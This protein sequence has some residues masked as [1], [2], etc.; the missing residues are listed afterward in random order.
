M[1]NIA[2]LIDIT[3]SMANE[4]EGVKQTVANLVRSVFEGNLPDVSITIIT[5]TETGLACVVTS[6]SFTDGDEAV[7]FVTSINLCSPPGTGLT[8]IYGGSNGNENQKAA[9]AELLTLDG[10]VPTIAFHITDDG[11]HLVAKQR[12]VPEAAVEAEYLKTKHGITDSDL[13]HVLSRVEAHFQGNLILSVIKYVKWTRTDDPHRLYGAIA[14]QF[15]GVLITPKVSHPAL[16]AAGLVEILTRLFSSFSGSDYALEQEEDVGADALASFTFYNLETIDTL[17][18]CEG[19]ADR[20]ETLRAGSTEDVMYQLIERATVIVGNKFAKRAIKATGMQEQ[21]E[22]LLVAAK[23]LTKSMPLNAALDRATELLEKIR[24]LVPE[25]NRGHIKIQASDLPRLLSQDVLAR[26]DDELNEVVSAIT[27]LSTE[28]TAKLSLG[29]GERGGADAQVE[30]GNGTSEGANDDTEERPRVDPKTLLQTVGS[31]F[32][33][34]LAVLQL[35]T[36]NG[37]VDF[38]DSWSSVITKVSNDV[39]TASDFLTMIGSRTATGGLSIRSTEYNY[40]QLFADPRDRVGSALFELASGTQVLDILTG[41][42]AGA[43][44]TKFA[45]NMFRG[46]VAACLKTLVIQFEPAPLSSFQREIVRKLAH[47]IRLLMGLRPKEM[48]VEPESNVSKLLFQLLRLRSNDGSADNVDSSSAE[49]TASLRST[50]RAYLEEVLASLVQG[51]LTYRESHYLA[52]VESMVGYEHVSE[53][54]DISETHALDQRV[55]EFDV[56]RA[57]TVASSSELAQTFQVSADNVLFTVFG[58]HDTLALPTLDD[59]WPSWRQ[60]LS[61]LILLGKRTARYAM[62]TVDKD[63][64]VSSA[65]AGVTTPFEWVRDEQKRDET[66]NSEFYHALAMG[67]LRKKHDAFLRMLRARRQNV[68][69]ELRWQRAL[70]HLR[71]PFDEF[72]VTLSRFSSSASRDHKLLLEAFKRQ[73]EHL[74]AAEYE[75]KLQVVITGRVVTSDSERIVFNR[76]NLHADPDRFVPMTDE[77]KAK[78]RGLQHKRQWSL[79][80]TYRPSGIPNRSGFSNSKL[81][82][83]AQTRSND[84]ASFWTDNM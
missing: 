3:G 41:L 70:K 2:F 52:L 34:H 71:S 6:H 77:F 11:P 78:L 68:Q 29:E 26:S 45:P 8:G 32:L 50:T 21:V 31:L 18:T 23:C 12:S 13:F 54:E 79:T 69:D 10:S 1:L 76:G 24:E 56:D 44:A 37:R 62:V 42:L 35:P 65:T 16:L 28:E 83:W 47:S 82:A 64:A 19:D 80:H 15:N 43:P 58:G 38:M 33:G 20:I 14:R 22:L 27:F 84:G 46:T 36:K 17:P 61:K 60:E 81:S 63:A 30:A 53:V 59:V 74:D 49:S 75:A 40:A 67:L 4:L 7:E 66:L 48:K 39:M 57:A 5:F 72:V 73:G 9:L 51:M 25:E 55:W